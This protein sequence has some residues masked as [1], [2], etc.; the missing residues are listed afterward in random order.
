[1][2]FRVLLFALITSLLSVANTTAS[3]ATQKAKEALAPKRYTIEQFMATT[4]LGSA[5]FSADEQRVLFQ[6]NA[7]GIF[8]AYTLTVKGGA[9]SALTKSTTDSTYAVS[10]FPN[11]DRVLFT[12]DKGGEIVGAQCGKFAAFITQKK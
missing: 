1:M 7:T 12:R 8:N 9:P 3:A 5:S 10:F 4:S 2:V 11:D 6:S